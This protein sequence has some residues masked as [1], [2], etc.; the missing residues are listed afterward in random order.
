M[1]TVRVGVRGAYAAGAGWVLE[2]SPVITWGGASPCVSTMGGAGAASSD[3]A[4]LL[5]IAGLV[6]GWVESED[7]EPDRTRFS[8]VRG[9]SVKAAG[10]EEGMTGSA[11]AGT[12]SG[13]PGTVAAEL[14]EPRL[15]V[16]ALVLSFSILCLPPALS[17]WATLR[18]TE[19]AFSGVTG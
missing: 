3:V 9:S 2:A 15:F 14:G 18:S 1:G 4:R 16:A 12:L 13:I 6:I 8:P 17:F 19:V 10:V 11:G 7:A 5:V